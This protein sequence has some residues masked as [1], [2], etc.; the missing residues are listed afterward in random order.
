MGFCFFRGRLWFF[1]HRYPRRR[2]TIAL[3][4][5]TQEEGERA[6]ETDTAPVVVC[7]CVPRATDGTK[8]K[9][10]CVIEACFGGCGACGVCLEGEW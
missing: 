1:H 6:G 10:G 5:T 4:V 9:A 8:G 3:C 7:G 2:H